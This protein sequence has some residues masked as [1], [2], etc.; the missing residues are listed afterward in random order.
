MRDEVLESSRKYFR[1]LS[2]RQIRP[3]H[4]YIPVTGKVLEEDDLVQLVEASL[5]MWLTAGRFSNEFESKFAELAGHKYALL[6]NS[7][8]SANLAAFTAL[9]SPLLGSKRLV[10]GD[11]VI[12]VAAGFPTTVNPIIQNQCVP[13]FVDVKLGTYQIDISLLESAL[14][15]KTKAVMVAHTLG[16]VFEAREVKDFCEKHNLWLI[17][18]CCDALGATYGGQKV[19]T[20]GDLATFS[21]YPAHHI[22]MGEGGA[23]ITSNPLLR[24]ASESIRDWGRD[25][26]CPPGKDNTCSKR[27]A[28]SLGGLPK[29]Y[30]HKYTYSH[31]GYNLKATDMQAAV[32][33]SQLSKL[34]KFIEKRRENFFYLRQALMSCDAELILPVATEGSE[35]SWFGFPLTVKANSKINR[36]SLV[37]YLEDQKIGTRLLFGGNLTKQP[38][39][40]NVS[41]RVVGELINTDII[42]NDC[43]WVGVWPGLDREHLDYIAHHIE[44]AVKGGE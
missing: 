10:P 25:C 29:G 3:G 8:S 26:W 7:G 33:I 31:V 34:K 5:D 4:D 9:T 13:V 20:F 35:P 18:D 21:F 43:F 38:A 1:S 2:P 15:S 23:L 14:S 16:N 6:V 19:G 40:T 37:R 39:Y 44:T 42:M 12:T 32:G 17:E 24:R 41:F 27:H 30:D 28:W 22:T 36:N 11:E